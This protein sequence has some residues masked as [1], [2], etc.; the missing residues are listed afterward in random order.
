MIGILDYG[1]GNPRSI[2][3]MCETSGLEAQIVSRPEDMKVS[4]RFVLPG[5]GSFDRCAQ[6]LRGKGLDTALIEQLQQRS[7]PLLGICVGAHLLG[8]SSEE[9]DESGL[10]LM[11]HRTVR[12]R[13]LTQPVPHM[14]W[15][16]IEIL[17]PQHFHSEHQGK[18]RFY[19]SHSYVIKATNENERF[20]TFEYE[21]TLDAILLKDNIVAVQFHPEKS[22]RFG[23]RLFEWFGSWAP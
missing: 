7:T 14:G 5:V 10:G 11:S 23:R 6:A 3:R 4:S 1:I 18:P 19:F 20:G 16:E 21:E 12:L 17:Q 13:P 8:T 22:H 2:L 9:G 15:K